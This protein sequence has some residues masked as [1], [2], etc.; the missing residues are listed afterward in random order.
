MKLMSFILLISIIFL[1]FDSVSYSSVLGHQSYLQ[2]T[3]V[4]VAFIPAKKLYNISD[5]IYF[6]Q[7]TPAMQ[8]PFYYRND[9]LVVSMTVDKPS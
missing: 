4:A 6:L 9:N 2:R 3:G 8:V 1:R 7:L 5:Y